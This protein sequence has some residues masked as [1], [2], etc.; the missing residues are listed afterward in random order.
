MTLRGAQ[1][2]LEGHGNGPVMAYLD[3]QRRA[4][5]DVQVVDYSQHSLSTGG[6]ARAATE[7]VLDALA[8]GADPESVLLDVIDTGVGIE[9]EAM[10][11]MFAKH[12]S[13]LHS[14]APMPYH[15]VTDGRPLPLA[16]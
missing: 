9:P 12:P 10:G 8:A 6:D 4:G 2:I 1:Q 7:V 13:F 16:Q 5:T 3:A 15:R 11:A 14:F